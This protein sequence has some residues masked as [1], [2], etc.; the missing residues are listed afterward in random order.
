[1]DLNF[2]IIEAECDEMVVEVSNFQIARYG[3]IRMKMVSKL[4]ETQDN[5]T[6]IVDSK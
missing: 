1:M 4:I 3:Y 6:S 5:I 2:S